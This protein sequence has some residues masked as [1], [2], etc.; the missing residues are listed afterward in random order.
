MSQSRVVTRGDLGAS[1]G[2]RRPRRARLVAAGLGAAA[3]FA[4]GALV[5]SGAGKDPAERVA[6][7][8]TTA[9]AQGDYQEMWKLSGG[10]RRPRAASRLAARYRSAAAT[11]TVASERFGEPVKLRDG[12]VRVPAVV[13]TRV[14]GTVRVP[15]V[16]RVHGEGDAARVAW[17]NE[18]LFPGMRRGERLRRETTLPERGDL[19]FRDNAPMS[20]FP[21]LA[22]SIRGTLGPPPPERAARLRAIGAPPDA[23]VGVSGLERVFD[24]RLLGRP[25][26]TLFGGNR[27]LASASAVAARPVRTTIAPK[28][29]RAAIDALAG[30]LGGAIALD[31]R[32]GEILGAS[33]VAWSA[34]Q[35]P[36]STFKII[37]AAGVL[38]AGLARPSTKFPVQNETTLS[39][40]TLENANGE[41]CGGTLF[42]SFAES[43]TS[44]FA[45]LGA[46]LGAKRLVS[47]ARRFGF[48][49]PPG[50][51]GAATSSL[52]PANEMG[53]DL[54][55]G[56]TAIGQGRVEATTLQMAIVAATIARDGVRPRPTLLLGQR[57]PPVRA[58]SP[59]VARRV[60]RL[61]RGVVK[62]GTG[63]SAAVPGVPVAGKTGTAELQTT[64]KSA[65]NQGAEQNAPQ[66]EDTSDTDAWFAAFAPARRKPPARVAV[67]VLLVRQG[68]GG[69]TAAPAAKGLLQAGLAR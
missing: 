16:L 60:R 66:S 53:D 52:P 25:G 50:I 59:R 69:D 4:V 5:G 45:P 26:G 54:A 31:P 8:F 27:V 33:G 49:E 43:C 10:P 36:G 68:A 67:A 7:Q 30:R 48:G 2:G 34:L 13:A 6:E 51:A 23:L 17:G 61:M 29:Q 12:V 58:V 19:R 47:V 24:E 42:Q 62:F 15:W 38:E 39:G 55:V 28:V 1:R 40:V 44:V 11:A 64:V 22:G 46:R 14:W 20:R 21:E 9:W 37:T 32:T 18:L 35:P 65:E 56:S 63:T 41:S 57:R 3:A